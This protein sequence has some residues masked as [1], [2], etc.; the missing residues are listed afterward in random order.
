MKLIGIKR[1]ILLAILSG[2]NAAI[3]AAYFLWIS[4]MLTDSQNALSAMSGE[5]S[6]LQGK[7]QNTKTELAQFKD[8]LP[9]YKTLETR[10]FM[11]AQDRF[12][13][14][15]D[16]DAVRKSAG[17]A[18]FNF[19]INDLQV[20]ESPE[21]SAAKLRVLNSRISV[22]QVSSLIDVNLY[23]FV[24]RMT[25]EFPAHVRLQQLTVR[26]KEPLNNAA[27]VRI[28]LRDP[29]NLVLASAIFDWITIV[30]ETPPVDP[31]NPNAP[32]P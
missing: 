8:N 28:S 25:K 9:K 20:V 21:A 2:I 26:R 12:Q 32:R 24:D 19:N 6:T 4:P 30:P 29:I 31:N 23:D 18:G 22:D 10:G 17:L 5:I 1:V 14:S 16:L 15:R 27:F 7:I 13:I 11:S 3:A